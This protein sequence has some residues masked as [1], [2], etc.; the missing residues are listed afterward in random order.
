MV[1]AIILI[2]IFILVSRN[3]FGKDPANTGHY[4]R[5]RRFNRGPRRPR[6]R[7]FP[8]HHKDIM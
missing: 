7:E 8:N 4:T 3:A 1:I 2:I 5:F 6:R